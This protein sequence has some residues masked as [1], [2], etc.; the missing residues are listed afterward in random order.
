MRYFFYCQDTKMAAGR[1]Q[2]TAITMK[3]FNL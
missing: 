1:P 3:I 2:N